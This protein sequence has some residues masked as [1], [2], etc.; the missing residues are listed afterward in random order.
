MSL[1]KNNLIC[2]LFSLYKGLLTEHQRKIFEM[3]YFDDFSLAEIAENENISR[4]AVKDALDTCEKN[5]FSFE[6][7]LQIKW[8]NDK[9]INELEGKLSWDEIL[10]V[11]KIIYKRK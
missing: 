3:Y 6:E 8:K 5:L 9:I 11:E 10:E 2:D 4:Q 7:K 1:E